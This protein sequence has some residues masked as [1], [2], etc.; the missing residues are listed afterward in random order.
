MLETRHLSRSVSFLAAAAILCGTQVAAQQFTAAPDSAQV[1]PVR[2]SVGASQLRPDLKISAKAIGSGIGPVYD[3]RIENVGKVKAPASTIQFWAMPPCKQS[4]LD[5][6]KLIKNGQIKALVVTTSPSYSVSHSVEMPKAYRGC[7]LR[8]VVDAEH[9]I[10]ELSEDNNAVTIETVL[11][12]PDLY[13]QYIISESSNKTDRITVHNIGNATAGPS[14]LWMRCSCGIEGKPELKTW[15]WYLT[16]L[17]PGKAYTVNAPTRVQVVGL[18]AVEVRV[19]FN[20]HI[21][22]SNENNN[23]F[24]PP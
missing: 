6:K 18:N 9:V 19:D 2:P 4:G 12:R 8:A 17:A 23:V 3:F 16:S 24:P 22:E 5:N 10:A 1:T 11:P 15:T 21:D 20:K 13:P 7:H 14:I